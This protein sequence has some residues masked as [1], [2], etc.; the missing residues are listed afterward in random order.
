MDPERAAADRVISS[1]AVIG[2]GTLGAQIAAMCA[3]SGRDV[4]LFDIVP[5]ASD[6]ALGRLRSLL[7]PVIARGAL[8]WDLDA[9]LARI[10]PA[11]TLGAAVAR[12]DLVIEAIRE[13]LPAKREIFS[14]ISVMNATALLATNSSS[15]PSSALADVVVDPTRLVNLHF[16]S[17]FWD[18]AAVELMGCGA[19]SDETMRK[20]ADFGRSLGLFTAVVRGESKG[21]II[22]RV[23]R[24]VKRE[25]LAVVDGGHA[26][27][28][29]VDRLW[30][31]FWGIGYGPFGMMDQ[32]GLDV[33][34]DIEDSYIAVS[35]DPTDHPSPAL[36][37]LVDAGKL[38]E[39][40]G[41]GFYRYPDPAYRTPG[42]PRAGSPS[43]TPP[44]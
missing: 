24:A 38:G 17:E 5:G 13:H 40:S 10:V 29:D 8:D 31:L 3:A 25:A 35:S 14:T 28:E 30:A 15:I 7:E 21:F 20:M 27:P 42:W 44:L 6:N 32:V 37:A 11:A 26:D 16:F 39:K 12:A 36:H 23:W 4:R 2:A 9:V 22:N 33:V 43:E 19:T 18:R 34:A 41:E 1:V